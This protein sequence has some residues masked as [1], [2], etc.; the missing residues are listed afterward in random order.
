[1]ALEL[2][3][4]PTLQLEDIFPTHH[5]EGVDELPLSSQKGLLHFM[6]AYLL[7]IVVELLVDI[8]GERL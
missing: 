1:M 7:L 6:I 8:I 3:G 2:V 5:V 4:G